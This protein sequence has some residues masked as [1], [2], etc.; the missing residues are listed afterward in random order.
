MH[1]LERTEI[2]NEFDN[3]LDS[4]DKVFEALY[5][6]TLGLDESMKNSDTYCLYFE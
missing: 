6:D 5:K 2:K 3:V 4:I 1:L